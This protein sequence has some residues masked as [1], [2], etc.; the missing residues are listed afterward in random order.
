MKRL[1]VKFKVS[2]INF[3][4]LEKITRSPKLNFDNLVMD[5]SLAL[6]PTSMS[7]KKRKFIDFADGSDMYKKISVKDLLNWVDKSIRKETI[8]ERVNKKLSV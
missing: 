6:F 1:P 4:Q 3:S 5:I 2:V 8:K 7:F